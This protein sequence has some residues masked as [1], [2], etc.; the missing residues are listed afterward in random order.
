MKSIKSN[1]RKKSQLR[2]N[3]CCFRFIFRVWILVQ[4]EFVC[5]YVCFSEC[6]FVF[7]FIWICWMFICCM[8]NT[9]AL[10]WLP[11]ANIVINALFFFLPL[12]FLFAHILSSFYVEDSTENGILNGWKQKTEQQP[13][14]RNSNETYASEREKERKNR[15][16]VQC[17]TEPKLKI[18]EPHRFMMIFIS[19]NGISQ[20]FSITRTSNSI[21]NSKSN[22][23]SRINNNKGKNPF[24]F[25]S[26]KK[27]VTCESKWMKVLFVF[28]VVFVTCCASYSHF[29][30]E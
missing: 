21:S 6:M 23:N 19:K 10:W 27:R 17:A 14:E 4:L 9:R 18:E 15:P 16:E 5:V 12:L 28:Q 24:F 7:V 29:L 20:R 11:F 13:S 25:F 1:E 3:E 30:L 8:L 22:S 2:L 26:K